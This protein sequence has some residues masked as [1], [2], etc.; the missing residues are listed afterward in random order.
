MNELQE[1]NNNVYT[2]DF[3]CQAVL[4]RNIGNQDLIVRGSTALELM[5]MFVGYM[6]EMKIEVYSKTNRLSNIFDYKITTCFENIDHYEIKGIRCTTFNQ[7]INDMLDEFETT[8]E[9][10]LAEALAKHYEQHGDFN[11]IN[12][13]PRHSKIFEDL[14]EW[15]MEYYM[16]G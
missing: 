12:I 5:G 10:A 14:K 1:N 8:D 4:S 3:S 6:T 2:A 13:N 15:A 11:S 9:V 16:E 7:T